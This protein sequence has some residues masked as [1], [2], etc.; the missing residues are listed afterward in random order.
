MQAK[1]ITLVSLIS[2]GTLIGMGFT[3][4]SVGVSAADSRY[5]M[6]QEFKKFEDN[7]FIRR[8]RV[9]IEEADKDIDMYEAKLDTGIELKVW[10]TRMYKK[11]LARKAKYTKELDD[12]LKNRGEAE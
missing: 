2:I 11:A 6:K 1:Q 7:L 10:E 8:V 5:V 3:A 4:W 12:Y 9:R